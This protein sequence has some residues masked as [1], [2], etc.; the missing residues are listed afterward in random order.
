MNSSIQANNY[1]DCYFSKDNYKFNALA[2]KDTMVN[3]EDIKE[4]YNLVYEEVAE[5][6]EGLKAN[7]PVEVLDGLVDSYVTLDGLRQKLEH[8]GVDVT[9]AMYRIVQNNLS[10]FVDTKELAEIAQKHYKDKGVA[11]EIEYNSFYQKWVIKNTVGKVMKPVGFESV[12]IADLIPA[13]IRDGFAS[14]VLS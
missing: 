12:E 4:Q 13:S 11:T 2:G 1:A 9:E 14:R 7:D 6:C 10:K 3:L 8:L 5:I